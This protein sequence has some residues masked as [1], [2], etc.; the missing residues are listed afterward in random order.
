[1]HNYCSCRRRR[2][3][4][5]DWSTDTENDEWSVLTDERYEIV[6]SDTQSTNIN[7]DDRELSKM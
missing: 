4:A 6:D 5:R 7:V 3:E 2:L 1:M